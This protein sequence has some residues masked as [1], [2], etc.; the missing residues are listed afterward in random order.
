VVGVLVGGF[1]TLRAA[2]TPFVVEPA[3]SPSCPLAIVCDP[4]GNSL[5]IHQRRAH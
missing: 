2:G 1:A 5:A 4:D 3:A